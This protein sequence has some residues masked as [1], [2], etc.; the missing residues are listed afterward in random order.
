[1]RL[2]KILLIISILFLF[3]C[4]NENNDFITEWKVKRFPYSNGTLTLL[5]NHKFE[6]KESEHLSNSFSNGLWNN[7]NDTLILNSEKPN[8]CYYI[9]DFSLNKKLKESKPGEINLPET[10]LKNCK[11]KIENKYFV[12]FLN[13]KFIIKKDSLIF[14]NLN[15]EYEKKYGNFKI[16][17]NR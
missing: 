13:S 1:M 16:Y 12:E 8:E 5:K 10:T 9:T 4:K 17:K 6:Y 14:L 3:S 7:I 15:K 2:E 11:P